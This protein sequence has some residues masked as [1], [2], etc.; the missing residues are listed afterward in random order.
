MATN[1]GNINGEQKAPEWIANGL[2]TEAITYAELFGKELSPKGSGGDRGA[3]TSSQIRNVYGEVI[4]INMKG[5]D[6][7]S[8][9]LLKPRLA[10]MTQRKGTDGSRDFHKVIDKALDAVLKGNTE[11]EQKKR[12][13][14]FAKFFEA[15]LAYH[16]SFGGK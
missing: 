3:L 1:L 9:L 5:Y 11:E 2:D 8:T 4:R 14:N 16:K 7:S 10:Y 13:D 15:I 12:F 6:K